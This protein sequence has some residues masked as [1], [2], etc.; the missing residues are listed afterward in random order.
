M[1]RVARA[2]LHA[3]LFLAAIEGIFFVFGAVSMY[4]GNP[5]RLYDQARLLA[6]IDS[7]L[8]TERA[9]SATGWPH[10]GLFPVRAHPSGD[11]AQCGTAWGGS[12]TYADDVADAEAWPHL[13]STALGCG[14]E[15]HGIDGFA[16]DQTLLHFRQYK[17]KDHFVI[18]GLAE[19]MI[20]AD[21]I[22]SWTFVML[23]DD[24]SP[25]AS[26]TKPFFTL[27]DHDQLRLTPRPGPT[28]DAVN[29]HIRGDLPARNW[30]EFKFPFSVR[31]A[32]AIYRNLRVRSLLNMVCSNRMNKPNTCSSLE[33]A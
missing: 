24:K 5:Y 25:K 10:Q 14:V 1:G 33:R 17:A 2:A 20:V 4:R 32:T 7:N 3:A 27:N 18:L 11:Q 26:V 23:N 29:D 9:G 28:V 13:L 12:F 22:A 15:N 30:T 6:A 31:V 19:P 21:G 8:P 16:V